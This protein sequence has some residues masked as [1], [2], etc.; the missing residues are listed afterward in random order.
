MT[1]LIT[2]KRTAII[3]ERDVHEDLDLDCH[4]IENKA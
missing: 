3:R 4:I 1:V 2:L